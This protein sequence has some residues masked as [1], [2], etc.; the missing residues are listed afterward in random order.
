MCTIA[1]QNQLMEVQGDSVKEECEE[2]SSEDSDED[3]SSS[4]DVEVIEE[5]THEGNK[6]VD[7]IGMYPII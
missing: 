6:L 2:V 7:S 3:L 1:G 4:S 5:V